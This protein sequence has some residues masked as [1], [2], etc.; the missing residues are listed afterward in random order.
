M[1][2]RTHKTQRRRLVRPPSKQILQL[3]EEGGSGG[4]G[5]CDELSSPPHQCGSPSSWCCPA[6]EGSDAGD[7]D[8][9]T[10]A[11]HRASS[12]FA[13][14]SLLHTRSHPNTPQ[15]VMARSIYRGSRA[16][17][18]G[19]RGHGDHRSVSSC[20]CPTTLPNGEPSIPHHRRHS[21]H[22]RNG[23]RGLPSQQQ[24][25]PLSTCASPVGLGGYVTYY[26]PSPI[27]ASVSPLLSSASLADTASASES[28][29]QKTKF[30]A[31]PLSRQ[32]AETTT[33]TKGSCDPLG[34][35]ATAPPTPPGTSASSTTG[36]STTTTTEHGCGDASEPSANVFGSCC[37][38]S[39]V[40]SSAATTAPSMVPS[41]SS[42]GGGCSRSVTATT[43]GTSAEARTSQSTAC[44][45]SETPPT[46][47][48]VASASP[49]T[50]LHGK[51]LPQSR[52]GF[53]N[54]RK[55][56]CNSGG[57]DGGSCSASASSTA[58]NTHD[59]P[60]MSGS[61]PPLADAQACSGFTMR[62]YCASSCG[63][64]SVPLT[65]LICSTANT[66]ATA[67]LKDS[68]PA[69][70][71][72]VVMQD[73]EGLGDGEGD[74]GDGGEGEDDNRSFCSDKAERWATQDAYPPS[75]QM[76]APIPPSLHRH[77]PT[78]LFLHLPQ[79]HEAALN[80]ENEK[81]ATMNGHHGQ[82]HRCTNP[83]AKTSPTGA[84]EKD[85]S[86]SASLQQQQHQQRQH[87]EKR[88]NINSGAPI[89]GVASLPSTTSAAALQQQSATAY[90]GLKR[91]KTNS[92]TK[93]TGPAVAA[94]AAAGLHL[95]PIATATIAPSA[96]STPSAPMLSKQ[97]TL[98]AAQ[99]AATIT[100]AE[101]HHVNENNISIRTNTSSSTVPTPTGPAP[102]TISCTGNSMNRVSPTSA[103]FGASEILPGLFLGAYSD[104]TN[105]EVLAAH[106]I[107]LVINCA[108]ECAVTP[109]MAHNP[110]HV[111][112]VQCPL[113]DHSDEVIST[114]FSSVTQII[115]EQLH[116]RQIHQ[117]RLNTKQSIG[118]H[119]CHSWCGDADEK[120]NEKD[121]VGAT[122]PTDAGSRGESACCGCCRR[123]SCPSA[124]AASDATAAV[125][126][127]SGVAA[128]HHGTDGALQDRMLWT[129]ADEAENVW[130]VPTSPTSLPLSVGGQPSLKEGKRET[131][132]TP[133]SAV[134]GGRT[135]DGNTSLCTSGSPSPV[136]D[137]T[138]TFPGVAVSANTASTPAGSAD[139][140]QPEAS[141]KG[142]ASVTAGATSLTVVDPRDCGG[143]LV[144]C[145][146]GV[147][148]SATFV[149]AYLILYGFTLANLEDTASLFVRFLERERA[150][151]EDAG[152]RAH[153]GFDADGNAAA[154]T[155]QTP[156][157]AVCTNGKHG[158]VP[159]SFTSPLAPSAALYR[160]TPLAQSSGCSA[161]APN[162]AHSG[163]TG[164]TPTSTA[165]STRRPFNPFSS[166]YTQ[167]TS[168]SSTITTAGQLAASTHASPSL[169]LHRRSTPIPVVSPLFLNNGNTATPCSTTSS[170]QLRLFTPLTP[171]EVCSRV[172]RP[173]HLQRLRERRLQQQQRKN[174]L[175]SGQQ[176][177]EAQQEAEEQMIALVAISRMR[178]EQ[179]QQQQQLSGNCGSPSAVNPKADQRCC[180]VFGDD[181][182]SN[183]HS[184]SCCRSY[185]TMTPQRPS[186]QQQ[187]Q[188]LS[189]RP[190]ASSAPVVSHRTSRGCFSG[191]QRL[192][193]AAL[194]DEAVAEQKARYADLDAASRISHTADD[195]V[196]E[197][198]SPL[199][200]FSNAA[201]HAAA[202]MEGP[203]TVVAPFTGTSQSP[204]LRLISTSQSYANSG[205]SASCASPLI[206]GAAAVMA[207]NGSNNILLHASCD[208]ASMASSHSV[209]SADLAPAMTFR[210]A[211]DAV[212]QQ[213]ADVNPNIGFVLAL[214][215][216][217]GGADFSF[218]TS[219]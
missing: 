49:A 71:P 25:R 120:R 123:T 102:P 210:E 96:T 213:K 66:Q 74:G 155:V 212:K 16:G 197:G 164:T 122:N 7:A 45:F 209:L 162:P 106:G 42:G 30:V 65:P 174:L 88:E 103:L 75:S 137:R 133:S 211:F 204:Q 83:H 79:Q 112:Y 156:T 199:S 22:H 176:Q 63:F 126:G 62:G 147:S 128:G 40:A 177:Q 172:C 145:R 48:A 194:D 189:L 24:Q 130:A 11:K 181:L 141:V 99:G 73:E 124:M 149:M 175:V 91:C 8:Q 127:D 139:P 151:I 184:D 95:L 36:T 115:H 188:C 105:T 207:V 29:T 87:E 129:W 56:V 183:H 192:L 182:C 55:R 163:S 185:E 140:L 168:S 5:H 203:D 76:I 143:I 153:F 134:A 57:G 165:L 47:A 180:A 144:H 125:A 109:A 136:P 90:E 161:S 92:T 3:R 41:C 119:E 173:C 38:T 166:W 160:I 64:P 169:G 39:C 142:S 19:M 117:Q 135:S 54:F 108:V 80:S 118:S 86:A 190:V 217:A 4:A 53:G 14:L 148:R 17:G 61:P 68:S 114:F 193:D 10:D 37:S 21:Q 111:R 178:G 27:T 82:V 100:A 94:K 67:T 34:D 154:S 195:D 132:C 52:V 107:S 2:T 110:H 104:S 186:K 205:P 113:R 198:V 152:G 72:L 200:S 191:M 202:T 58:H 93:H 150:L 6:K 70:A 33:M 201:T 216:L 9:A 167:R 138:A 187:Q 170:S 69:S 1:P 78:N 31:A 20:A 32:T 50:S 60:P 196:S 59:T 159:P 35:A 179:Q 77:H 81:A 23:S 89:T 46:Y 15:R 158:S 208:N 219:L 84:T 171:L 18:E 98:S 214:R 97:Q 121:D 51:R 131:P 44:K 13:S 218:S 146:M 215:E 116:R 26:G 28:S 157:T 85:T 12:A 101:Q 43:A 206:R